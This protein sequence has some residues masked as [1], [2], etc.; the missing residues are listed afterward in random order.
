LD[1]I[2]S[3]AKAN[4]NR[5]SFGYLDGVEFHQFTSRYGIHKLPNF[6][7]YDGSGTHFPHSLL[8]PF[9]DSSYRESDIITE[10]HTA[11]NINAFLDDVVAGKGNKISQN[12]H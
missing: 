2:K 6:F 11:E 10:P 9:L 5:F 3:V 1:L 7:V 4:K 8:N 12:F